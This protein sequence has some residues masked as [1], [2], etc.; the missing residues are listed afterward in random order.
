MFEGNIDEVSIFDTDQSANIATIYNSGEPTTISGAIAHYK[1]G[2][3][4]TLL[5]NWTVPDEVGTNDGT[6]VNMNVFDRV[7]EAPNSTSNSVSLNMD[8][9]DRVT[10]VPT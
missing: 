9:V 10:D 5:T 2:E 1:M 7:G 8:E 6:S 3:N 4:A